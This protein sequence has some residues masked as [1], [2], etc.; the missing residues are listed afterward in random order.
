MLKAKLSESLL[1][2][3][4]DDS[5]SD[6]NFKPNEPYIS[7]SSSDKSADVLDIDENLDFP[8]F[9]PFIKLKETEPTVE[10]IN[11]TM[12]SNYDI[13]HSEFKFPSE[14]SPI[15]K[16]YVKKEFTCVH[17]EKVFNKL[18][19][20]NLHLVSVHKIK[21]I[22]NMKPFECPEENCSFACGNKLL[23]DR[24]HHRPKDV[25]ALKF[26]CSMC[27]EKCATKSSLT[28]HMKRKHKS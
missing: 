17:C 2:S 4:L 16:P 18:Y 28:R 20:L 24:H 14:T 3:N 12:K 6:T 19:N 5:G 10:V 15:K 1:D 25:H 26:P 9:N 23:F 8:I 21:T 27:P 7:E 13:K 11:S 22:K